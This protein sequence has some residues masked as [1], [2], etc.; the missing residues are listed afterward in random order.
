MHSTVAGLITSEVTKPFL[1]RAM[2]LGIQLL[3]IAA[4][5]DSID[6]YVLDLGNDS[7]YRK[8]AKSIAPVKGKTG[9][10]P[11]KRR[12]NG[13]PVSRRNRGK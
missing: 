1:I 12:R 11:K 3:A 10:K 8:D 6:N 13:P 7:L 5:G 4:T 2:K 9:N